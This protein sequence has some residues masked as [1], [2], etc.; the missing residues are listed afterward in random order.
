MVPR[1]ASSIRSRREHLHHLAV[2]FQV[3]IRLKI[4]AELYLRPMSPKEFHDEFGGGSVS[5][6]SHHFGVLVRHGWLRR[7]GQKPSGGRGRSKT[8][9]RATDTPFFDAETWTLLPYSLRLAYSWSSFK[10]TAK[11]LREGIHEAN[12]KGGKS[13]DLTCTQLELDE[14]GWHRVIAVLDSGFEAVFE[15][16]DDARVRAPHGDDEL[17]RVG[18]LRI[19]FQSPDGLDLL[20]ADLAAGGPEPPIPFPE[21]LAPILADDLSMEILAA[22]NDADLSIAGFHGQFA[23][24]VSQWAVRY[25]FARMMELGWIA[26]VRKVKRRAI[27]EHIYRATKP[28]ITDEI[29]TGAPDALTKSKPWRK[30]ERFSDLAKEAIIAGSFDLRDNRHLSWSIVNLDQVGWQ[31]AIS[32]LEGAREVIEMER[33]GARKRIA[34]G[35]KP[36]TMTVA[37]GAY[38]S[39]AVLT[40]AP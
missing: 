22:L 26:V 34:D 7:V 30:F 18:I 1:I 3:Q 16:Q 29:W 12:C 19:G 23:P 17:F 4:V 36:L 33:E 10:A 2:V 31:N 27:H 14:L 25:R 28:A 40:K 8:L 39:P 20:A 35:A 37:L 11:E 15:E 6:V 5:R 9:Y 32:D 21:R 13:R 38:E 24:N